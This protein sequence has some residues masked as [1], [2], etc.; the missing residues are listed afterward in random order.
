MSMTIEEIREHYPDAAHMVYAHEEISP[1][2]WDDLRSLV[3][4]GTLAAADV[5]DRFMLVAQRTARAVPAYRKYFHELE[6]N[7]FR[8]YLHAKLGMM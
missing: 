3:E 5:Y 7:D 8:R 4:N 2:Y 1:N 6:T